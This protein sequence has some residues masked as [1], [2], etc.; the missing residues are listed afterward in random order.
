MDR[1]EGVDSHVSASKRNPGRD[2][3]VAEHGNNFSFGGAGEASLH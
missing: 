1:M 2:A 3:A